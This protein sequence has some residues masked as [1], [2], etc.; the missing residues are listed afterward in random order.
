LEQV[1][2]NLLSNALKYGAPGKAIQIDVRENQRNAEAE[3]SVANR[4]PGISAND[5]HLLFERFVRLPAARTSGT[6]GSGL[7]LYIAKGLIEAHGGRIW[8]ESVP[9]ETTTF[10]FTLPLDRPRVPMPAPPSRDALHGRY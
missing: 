7:G 4:G 9:G 1:V 6:Q 2:T 5:L 3:V 10:H 8:A